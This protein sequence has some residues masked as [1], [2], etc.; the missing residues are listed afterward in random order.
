MSPDWIL[1]LTVPLALALGV[2][3]GEFCGRRG[4]RAASAFVLVMLLPLIAKALS[5]FLQETEVSAFG[6]GIYP[7]LR[8][9]WAFPFAFAVLSCAA[10]T[11]SKPSER[12]GLRLLVIGL[13][14]LVL[15]R[16]HATVTADPQR[17]LGRVDANGICLQTSPISCGAA[18]A[19]MLLDQQG[20]RRTEARMA[21]LCSTNA[22]TGTDEFCVQRGLV[23]V[24]E[25]ECREWSV[26]YSEPSLEELEA[27]AMVPVRLSFF[28]DH[29]VVVES[30]D[31]EASSLVILDPI[32]G[33]VK[34][35][36]ADFEARWRSR[37]IRIVKREG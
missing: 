18:A 10:A 20:I 33:R 19:V 6:V 12:R 22:L 27:P 25:E 4:P 3:C 2:V 8:P 11:R 14:L 17:L 36:L 13:S 34:S 5:R 28:V 15:Q 16:V 21:E 31:G 32:E 29:W 37:V 24:L 9:W 1:A 35:T 23:K 26:D 7:V 30:I